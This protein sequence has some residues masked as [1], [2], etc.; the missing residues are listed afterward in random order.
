[1]TSS[2]SCGPQIKGGIFGRTIYPLSLIFIGFY[3]H[4][5]GGGGYK[6]PLQAPEDKK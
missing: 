4:S 2:L 5:H 6:Q 1:M 3:L